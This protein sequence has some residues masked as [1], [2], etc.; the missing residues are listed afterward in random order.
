MDAIQARNDQIRNY[1]Y[2]LKVYHEK[3]GENQFY[4]FTIKDKHGFEIQ[5]HRFILASQSE[6]FAGLFRMDPTASETTFEDFS[7][8]EI[9]ICIDFLYSHQVNLTDSCV[10]DVLAFADFISLS[11]IADICIEHIINNMNESNYASVMDLGNT[12]SVDCLIEAAV[13]FVTKN[14]KRTTFGDFTKKMILKVAGWQQKRPTVMTTRQWVISQLKNEFVSGTEKVV[15]FQTRCSSIY[16]NRADNW[17][18]QLA[19][20]GKI[21]VNNEGYFHSAEEIYPWLEV[22]LPSPIL[23]LSLTIINR[24]NGFCERLRN[25]EIRAGLNP[26]P[27]DFTAHSR[28]CHGNKQLDANFVCG[29]FAGPAVHLVEGPVIMFDKPI[30]A[31]YL[32]LQIMEFG[33]LQINGLKINGGAILNSADL[34][35]Q[36]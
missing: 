12:L 6:Y 3:Q 8:D 28:D 17:G 15:P 31:Q 19:V 1:C 22:K 35:Q 32:T 30:L 27:D 25:L 26:V 11:D 23:I 14:H 36:E 4:D 16:L 34:I 21:S 29:H 20:N 5:S 2:N 18:P 33:I 9:K 13:F 24:Q 10:Q 7:V